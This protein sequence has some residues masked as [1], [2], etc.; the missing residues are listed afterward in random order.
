MYCLRI[1]SILR[2]RA[3]TKNAMVN[4]YHLIKQKANIMKYFPIH[5]LCL[6]PTRVPV[7][8]DESMSRVCIE[9]KTIGYP[10]NAFHIRTYS[11][12]HSNMTHK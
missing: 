6:L 10:G 1:D 9:S 8:A 2:G 3:T 12:E 11:S 5:L 4:Q 7:R